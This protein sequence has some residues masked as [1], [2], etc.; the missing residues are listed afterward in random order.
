MSATGE[1][2]EFVAHEFAASVTDPA[3]EVAPEAART[4]NDPHGGVG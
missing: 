2:E 4:P 1:S 3:T